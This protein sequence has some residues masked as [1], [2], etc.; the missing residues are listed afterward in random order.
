MNQK[1][2]FGSD[3]YSGVA[4]EIMEFIV[5]INKGHST[6]YGEDDYTRKATELFKAEFG[7]DIEVFFLYN[8]TAANTLALG[9][10]TQSYNSIICSDLS[11]IVIHEVTAP[12]NWSGCKFISLPTEDGKINVDQIQK[13]YEDETYW[14][15]HTAH[16]KVVS[17][18]Q[19]TEL[20]TLYS[21]EEIKNIAD[22][23]HKNEMYLHM[24]GA[25][26][27]N[28]CLSMEVNF[29]DLTKGCGVDVLSF[30]ATKNGLMFGEAL[31]FFN[32][33]LAKDFEYVQK[34]GMQLHSKMRFLSAQYI[35]YLG[36]RIWYD[37][38]ENSNKMAKLLGEQL[39]IILPGCMAFPVVT[40]Q[41]FAYFPEFAIEELLEEFHFYVFNP[42]E[43]IVRL[44]TSFDTTEEEVNLFC[45]KLK[46]I[47]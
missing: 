43:N 41:I 12:Q 35:P 34:Q 23:C 17:I 36:K 22:Y 44:V 11:H 8:G 26:I 33:S 2:S 14:G 32:Q 5:K 46:S 45:E 25:R 19:P 40:N 29:N 15:R 18:S 27:S 47:V 42:R 30:G 1:V 4:P 6:G 16:P 20:G 38:A 37:N 3:N 39:N 9:K 28:A 31:V 24:D 21:L 7:Q 10:M 13:V